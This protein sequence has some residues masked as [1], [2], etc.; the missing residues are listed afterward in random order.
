MPQAPSFHP[1]TAERTDAARQ[2]RHRRGC[3]CASSPRPTRRRREVQLLSNGRYHVDGHQRRRR[4]Q[5]LAG[6]GRHALARGPTRDDWGSF[7]YLRDVASGEFWSTAHQPTLGR[8]D[9]YEA[10]FSE[11][12][13][14]FRRRDHGIDTH[15]EIVVSPEDDIEL[16]RVRITNRSRDAAHDRAHQLRRGGARRRRRP[17]RAPGVQQAVRADRA[18][19][20]AAGASCARAGRARPD[21]RAPWMFQLIALQR[22]P[23]RRQ[24]PRGGE[25]RRP[26]ATRPTARASSAAAA[27]SPRRR[28]CTTPGRCRTPPA[29]CS[30]R[31]SP[32]AC[33]VTLG[34]RPDGDRRHRHRHGREPRGVRRAGRE[35]PR[36]P[37]RRPRLRA[38]LDARP[39]DAAPAQ[40]QRGRRAALRP[41]GQRGAST[42]QPRCAPTRACC[43]ATAAAS[44]ACGATP[45]PAT[46]RSCCCR[47]ATPPTSTWCASWCRRTRTGA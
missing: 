34:A 19:R 15:T 45:S 38:G 1:Q 46:C 5:P 8:A 17:T 40:R 10:I 25:R 44:P 39:G 21:E 28:R 36:P 9:S 31:S 27:R 29:R 4:L 2:R 11:G 35:V 33:A 26:S 6:P 47:S 3:R 42:P 16:R 22:A 13:A 37:P 14:E 32:S 12:R 43:C 24:A 20:R 41:A 7:C 23:C 18:A 30:T